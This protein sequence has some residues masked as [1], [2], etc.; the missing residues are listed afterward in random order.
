LPAAQVV[1]FVADEPAAAAN[2]PPVQAVHD[3]AP[4]E[5]QLVPAVHAEQTALAVVEHAVDA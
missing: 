3:V 5:D 2:E 1:Q 4:A